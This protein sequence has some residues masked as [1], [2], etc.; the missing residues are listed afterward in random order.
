MVDKVKRKR[1]RKSTRTTQSQSQKVIVNIGSGYTRKRTAN[2]R[3]GGGRS[4]QPQVIYQPA[5]IPLQ[6]NYN[7][8]LND[9][10]KEIKANKEQPIGDRTGRLAPPLPPPPP[11]EPEKPAPPD[12]SLLSGLNAQLTAGAVGKLKQPVE[13][14]K[15]DE[16]AEK[17]RSLLAGL[18]GLT[19][20][21]LPFQG[22]LASGNLRPHE[23]PNAP[24][25]IAEPVFAEAYP[26]GRSASV[27]P[28]LRKQRSDAGVKRGPLFSTVDKSL[29]KEGF[30][31]MPIP[32]LPPGGQQ[33][34][35]GKQYYRTHKG[36]SKEEGIAR[37]TTQYMT[38]QQFKKQMRGRS[39]PVLPVAGGG[40]S[41]DETSTESAVPSFV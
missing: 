5:P 16:K 10:R 26:V 11:V 19:S 29:Q 20:L 38:A 39:P 30:D 3:T 22:G 15:P 24:P 28:R 6:P 35:V 27:P 33:F 8:Q 4:S 13:P 37:V 17:T 12:R 7:T 34:K 2:P 32:T 21:S 23:F 9:L 36:E 40:S 14:E 25:P 41:N 18:E 1:K 31:L